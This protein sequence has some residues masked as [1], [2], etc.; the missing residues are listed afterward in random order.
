MKSLSVGVLALVLCSGGA[1]RALAYHEV[2]A[3]VDTC[4]AWTADRQTPAGAPALQDE[5]WVLG[6]LTGIGFAGSDQDDPLAGM[7]AAGVWT[8]I[9]G[10]CQQHPADKIVLAARAFFKFHRH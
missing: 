10:Y 9:D 2:G 4:A 7:D 1:G 6:F 8:W 5:Q 3:G